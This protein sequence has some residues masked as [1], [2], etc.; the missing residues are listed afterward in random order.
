MFVHYFQIV[1]NFLYVCQS[2]SWLTKLLKLGPYGDISCSGWDIFPKIFGDI[3]GIFW[4]YFQINANCLYVF[5]SVSWLTFL[6]ILDK[7]RD[8]SSSGW[9][10][11]LKHFGDIPGMLLHHFQIYSN[12]LYA[13]Q[14]FINKE[15]F[16]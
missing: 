6:Q 7:Y 13:C 10:N 3:P 16:C 4:H 2:I 8:I 14:L 12:F 9:D 5:Q 11:F 1:T 15:I